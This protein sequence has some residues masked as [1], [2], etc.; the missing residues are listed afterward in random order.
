V[1]AILFNTWVPMPELNRVI[2]S[3][4]HAGLTL[5]LFL[6]GSGLSKQVLKSTGVRPMLQ[7]VIVWVLIAGGT[8]LAVMALAR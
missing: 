2:V 6:I 1:L 7:G 4:A 5:T 3:A 8:L